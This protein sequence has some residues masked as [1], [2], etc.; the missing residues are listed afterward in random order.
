MHDNPYLTGKL[1]VDKLIVDKSTLS[2]RDMVSEDLVPVLTIDRNVH[3][4]P[5]SRL[6]FEESL[7][8]QE[9][10]EEPSGNKKY[11]CRVIESG[12]VIVG[13]LVVC[14]IADELHILNIATASQY[15]GLGVG[16]LL[17]EE[18]IR[19]SVVSQHHKIFLEVR[20]SNEIA[21]NLYLKW[22]FEK[23][24]IRKRYYSMPNSSNTNDRE[25]A[26]VFMRHLRN[27]A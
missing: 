1:A 19:L 25:D 13:Y 6:S 26:F 22:Q 3:I 21:Q 10:G 2:I 16:H 18:I 7:T 23:I 20:A 8:M 5:W 15:Q 12:D 11:I 27:Q 9:C 14:P 24:S 4:S 17:M